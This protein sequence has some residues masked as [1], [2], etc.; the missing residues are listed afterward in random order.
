MPLLIFFFKAEKGELLKQ[1]SILVLSSQSRG[2]LAAL[3]L[4]MPCPLGV[5]EA[6]GNHAGQTCPSH[7]L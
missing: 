6:P 2:C 4:E 7:V 1:L 5:C 3:W